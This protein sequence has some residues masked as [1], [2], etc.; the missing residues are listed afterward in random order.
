MAVW[1]VVAAPWL[2]SYTDGFGYSCQLGSL[3][4]YSHHIGEYG[5]RSSRGRSGAVV[6]WDGCE[7]RLC[8]RVPVCVSRLPP[9]SFYR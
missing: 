5:I 1:H 9:V 6:G 3:S 8:V 2:I 7:V 4:L